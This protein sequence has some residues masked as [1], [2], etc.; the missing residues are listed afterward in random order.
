MD[1]HRTA[2][3]S[4]ASVP[5][6]K[7]ADP[8]E[9]EL[10]HGELIEIINHFWSTPPAT[11]EVALSHLGRY[12]RL[13]APTETHLTSLAKATGKVGE[14]T[15]TYNGCLITDALNPA[16]AASWVE[17][18][19]GAQQW[20]RTSLGNT[21]TLGAVWFAYV[22]RYHQPEERVAQYRH[23]ATQGKTALENTIPGFTQHIIDLTAQLLG[24][25]VIERPG[26]AGPSIINF[27]PSSAELSDN[28]GDIHFDWMG[29]AS[30]DAA[31]LLTPNLSF[32]LMLQNADVGGS[33][34]LWNHGFGTEGQL[35]TMAEP[36]TEVAYSPGSLLCFNG[37]Q[38]HQ[39][40]AI[41][42]QQA[43]VTVTWHAIRPDP[44][45]PWHIWV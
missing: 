21:T 40:Q 41:A 38:L 26:W 11:V 27:E 10:N 37:H 16:E 3:H 2:P 6:A 35:V 14:L 8:I 43:R 32:V 22:D 1:T 23:G 42:G 12:S 33:L 15:H 25:E 28:D 29:I 9:V 30:Q 31:G 17:A 4:V 44:T 20:D 7:D 39:I 18:S 34:K 24:A 13:L 36:A 5:S 19:R 45:G